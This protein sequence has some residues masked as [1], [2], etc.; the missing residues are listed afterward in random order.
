MYAYFDRQVNL[1]GT[2]S[3]TASKPYLYNTVSN[4]YDFNAQQS[5]LKKDA[6]SWIGRKLWNEHLVTVKGKNYWFVLD[7]ILDLQL[8][9]NTGG[10]VDN[11]YN[12]T[13]GV[14][15]QGGLGKGFNF[16]ATILRSAICPSGR[17]V[18][19]TRCL[20]SSK[21]VFIKDLINSGFFIFS[22]NT[23]NVGSRSTK[24]NTSP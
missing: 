23:S 22:R 1:V 9:K 14:Q 10:E 17:N 6:S 18:N 2:N 24:P 11:T 7:P 15:V 8:G 12:N 16:S 21:W 20:F 3:H 19:K 5:K 4:Y 13:R